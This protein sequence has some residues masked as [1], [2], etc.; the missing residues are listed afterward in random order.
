MLPKNYW[1]HRP[2]LLKRLVPA[3][4]AKIPTL[5]AKA[6]A[7]FQEVN[8][9]YAEH[10]RP[11]NLDRIDM[12]EYGVAI[13]LQELIFRQHEYPILKT[14]DIYNLLELECISAFCKSRTAKPLEEQSPH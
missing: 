3:V 9:F 13:K 14:L 6:I 2:R 4:E 7:A 1:V 8:D 5:E 10:N 11:P 12:K